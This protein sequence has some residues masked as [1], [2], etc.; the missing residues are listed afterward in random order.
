MVFITGGQR[1]LVDVLV[2]EQVVVS[3]TADLKSA[4]MEAH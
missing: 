4:I 3:E 2:L 1:P